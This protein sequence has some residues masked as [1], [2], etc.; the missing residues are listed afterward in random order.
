MRNENT[1]VGMQ[2]LER[3][4][5]SLVLSNIVLLSNRFPFHAIL[6]LST[7]KLKGDE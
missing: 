4:V 2:E 6:S 5:R 1:W 7:W 3:T